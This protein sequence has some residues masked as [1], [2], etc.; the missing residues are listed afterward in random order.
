MIDI[1][2]SGTSMRSNGQRISGNYCLEAVS[3]IVRF[4]EDILTLDTLGS[5][6]KLKKPASDVAA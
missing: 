2:F 4:P 5:Q 6:C 1:D 3:A